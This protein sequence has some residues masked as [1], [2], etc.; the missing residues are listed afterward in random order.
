MDSAEVTMTL[1][2]PAHPIT[3]SKSTGSMQPPPKPRKKKAPTLRD[4]DWEP[5]KVRITGLYTAGTTLKDVAAI[6]KA[7]TGFSAECVVIM[8]APKY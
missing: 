1:S 7:E 8:V 5:H 2:S 4:N 6:I 3:I